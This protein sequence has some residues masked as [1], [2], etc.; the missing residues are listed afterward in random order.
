MQD[1]CPFTFADFVHGAQWKQCQK[2]VLRII[3]KDTIEGC[4]GL[5][6]ENQEV[7]QK[8]NGSRI[9]E[10]IAESQDQGS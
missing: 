10:D 8:K 1:F 3:R 5:Q 7:I 2:A 4:F 6:E 9:L